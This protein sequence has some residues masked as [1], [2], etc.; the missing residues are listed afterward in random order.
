MSNDNRLF[1]LSLFLILLR[2]RRFLLVNIAAAAILM[3]G[4]SLLL[5]NW[6]RGEAVILPPEAQHQ[7]LSLGGLVPEIVGSMELPLMASPSDVIG[8]MA[9][10]R[11][12][13]D[14]VIRSLDLT[15]VLGTENLDLAVKRFRGL[16]DI[17]VLENGIIE[18]GYLD[19]DPQRAAIV[20]NEIVRTLDGLNREVRTARARNNR[21]FIESR[22]GEIKDSLGAAEDSL[23]AFSLRNK[24]ISLDEQAKAQIGIV[25]HLEAER[26]MAET[27][28]EILRRSLTPDHPE[29]LKL[30]GRVEGLGERISQ[31][32]LGQGWADSTG[33]LRQPLITQ[34]ELAL[35]LA[36]LTRTVKIHEALYE[37][38]SSQ[39]EQARIEESK[40]TPTLSV[41]NY[42]SVPQLKDRPKRSV[43]VLIAAFVAA[44][45]S[46]LWIWL[47]E[48]L[49]ATKQNDPEQFIK[50]RQLLQG[51]WLPRISR[52]VGKI[53]KE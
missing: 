23:A 28:L 50:L 5:P 2:W 37:L 19:R 44:V 42:A 4:V 41:L 39:Y 21:T 43:M 25:A 15:E 8:S 35:D 17:N 27:E 6:Y 26:L 45:V 9:D 40:T 24:A 16:L 49:L 53:L 52:R 36:R 38:L 11:A 34:P 31:L 30:A 33:M 29:V 48:H 7:T 20:T 14:S 3:V 13:L 47:I 32:E 1:W 46:L 51:L 18:I 12:V 10:S 22:L